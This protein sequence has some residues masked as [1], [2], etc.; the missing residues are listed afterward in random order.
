LL[1][2]PKKW[3]NRQLGSYGKVLA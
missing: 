2:N 3:T 1:N